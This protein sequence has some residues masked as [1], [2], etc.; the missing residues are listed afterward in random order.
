MPQLHLLGTGAALSSS[1]RTTTMLAVEGGSVI[2]IDCGGDVVQRLLVAGIDLAAIRLLIITHEHPD[3]V[4]GFPLFMEKMW[5]ARRREPVPVC[6]PA[7][8]ITVARTLFGTFDTSGWKDLPPIQ[9]R[10]IPLEE[11]ATV[12]TDEEWRIIASPGK[13]SVPVLGIRIE[14]VTDGGVLAY[15]ADTERSN[16]IVRLANGADILV[17]EATG[18]FAGHTSPAGAAE[19]AREAG[20]RKLVLVHLPPEPSAAELER[21]VAIFPAVELGSDGARYSF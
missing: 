17:H 1:D 13:H 4:S 3:H 12:W 6:G 2:V 8:A 11:E 18:S 16:A 5:L 14:D 10:E 15:S 20:A 21:A 7:P 19:V 9:W